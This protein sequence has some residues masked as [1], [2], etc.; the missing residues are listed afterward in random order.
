MCGQLA[1]EANFGLDKFADVSGPEEDHDMD[2][3][4]GLLAMTKVSCSDA[5]IQMI[6]SLDE[7][8]IVP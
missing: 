3:S 5:I 6:A 1:L 8:F 2:G 4:P 7:S